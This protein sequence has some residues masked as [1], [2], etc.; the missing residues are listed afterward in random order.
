V[1]HVV[2]AEALERWAMER[3]SA[4]EAPFDGV[5]SNFAALNCVDDLE[6][7][8]G[9]AR[10]LPSVRPHCSSLRY[11]LLPAKSWCNSREA[12]RAAA[13]RR[14]ARCGARTVGRRAFDVRYHS[15]GELADAMAPWFR[16]RRRI[17]VGVLVPPSA[18]EPWISRHPA[19]VRAL[20]RMD[21]RTGS[22]VRSTRRSRA[23]LVR[24]D[25]CLVRR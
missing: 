14:R 6:T 13:L 21:S 20:E 4:G 10:L 1:P 24:A 7:V 22:S 12:T 25:G 23:V 19:L 3:E 18:A 8:R 15:A 11:A 16:L 17:G 2:A 5:F 9:L